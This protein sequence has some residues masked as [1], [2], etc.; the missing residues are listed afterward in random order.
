MSYLQDIINRSSD[1]QQLIRARYGFFA[2]CTI[3]VIYTSAVSTLTAWSSVHVIAATVIAPICVGLW[4]LLREWY[5][6]SGRGEKIGIVFFGLR[7]PL[8]ELR[9]TENVFS[10]L[11]EQRKLQRPITLRLFPDSLTVT[12]VDVERLCRKYSLSQVVRVN[13]SAKLSGAGE[14]V[15]YSFHS[16]LSE[17]IDS[18]LWASASQSLALILGRPE[19]VSR[20]DILRRRAERLYEIVLFIL[21]TQLIN[22]MCPEEAVELLEAL[23]ESLSVDFPDCRKQPRL[24]VRWMAKNCRLQPLL[25]R[26]SETPPPGYARDNWLSAILKTANLYGSEYPETLVVASRALFLTGRTGDA[27]A[28]LNQLM[29]GNSDP[30]Y[31]YGVIGKAAVS[32]LTSDYTNAHKYYKQFVEEA[33]LSSFNWQDLVDFADYVA[34]SGYENAVFMQVLY[35]KYIPGAEILAELEVQLMRWFQDNKSR[36]RL[37]QILKS[38]QPL[39]QKEVPSLP[40]IMKPRRAAN[41]RFKRRKR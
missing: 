7:V 12:Q 32:L 23:D 3:A 10:R 26:A 40:K 19:G 18:A 24:A 39:Q 38:A 14:D 8:D 41:E 28:T 31:Y 15:G 16:S 9:I 6:R 22:D 4:W 25:R 33:P 13:V 1:P 34:N 30:L 17:G 21:S 2:G 11:V 35:R 27:I 37:R 20:H 29:K 5:W 36:E